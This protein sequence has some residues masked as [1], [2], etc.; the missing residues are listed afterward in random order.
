MENKKLSFEEGMKRL[1]EIVKIMNENNSSLEDTMSMYEE[2]QKIIKDLSK[3]LEENKEK[4]AK[5]VD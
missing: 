4:I 1:D 3:Q 2:A 5:Y